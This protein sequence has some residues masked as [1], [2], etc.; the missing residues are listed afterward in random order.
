MAR[1][2]MVDGPTHPR[3]LSELFEVRSKFIKEAYGIDDYAEIAIPEINRI[4]E[5][6]TGEVNLWFDED[7]FCQ[8]NLWFVCSLLYL[9]NINVNLVIPENSLQYGFAGLNEKELLTTFE[10]RMSL[11]PINVNQFASLWFSYRANHIERLLKSGVQMYGEFPFV[12]QAIEAHY[13]R[14]P[15]DGKPGKLEQVMVEIIQELGTKD[16]RSLFPE[17]QKRTQRYGL[18]DLQ[19]K[20]ILNQLDKE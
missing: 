17:F 9:K 8:T 2:C 16:F 13:D 6:Q 12:M 10:N 15:N 19:V 3:K 20:R 5:I 4:T 11:T 14:L 1:E 7:L 18:G